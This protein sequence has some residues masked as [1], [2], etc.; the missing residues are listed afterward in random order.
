MKF[1]IHGATG[2]SNFGDILFAQLFYEETLKS[3]NQAA[4]FNWPRI[5]MGAHLAN[6]L[7]IAD[8]GSAFS[9]M[10]ADAFVLMSG[11]YLGINPATGTAKNELIILLR[12]LLP[13]Y[14]FRLTRKPLYIMGVG[15][16]PL[17]TRLVRGL[18][19]WLMKRARLV[20]VRDQATRDYFVSYGVK[21]DIQVTSDTA[22][23][24]AGRTAAYQQLSPAPGWRT[25]KSKILFFHL[26]YSKGEIKQFTEKTIPAINAFLRLHKEYG[27][28][29]GYDNA[30]SDARDT[31][32]KAELISAFE[33]DKTFDFVYKN[34]QSLCEMLMASDLVITPKLHVGI[35]AAA[36]SKSV[37]S[38]PI[39]AEKIPRFYQQIGE[40]E[41]CLPLHEL[42]K[43][44]ALQMLETYHER[45]ITIPQELQLAA[46]KNL[47][48]LKSGDKG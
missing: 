14:L 46:E 24:L 20:Y 8:R 1:V 5:G 31:T 33:T 45:R 29:V 42:T 48:F 34:P 41:R 13:A 39:H 12:Y 23:L 25:P 9:F 36:F 32:L 26:P 47:D 18:A 43:D 37:L 38:F 16:G 17:N 21:R 22:L 30:L 15:G 44:A 3:G 4:F 27:V 28:A 7:K 6:Y 19:C 35:V 2:I 40:P 11:G 10:K